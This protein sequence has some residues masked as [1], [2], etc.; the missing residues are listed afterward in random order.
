MSAAPKLKEHLTYK[1]YLETSGNDYW[2][3]IDGKAYSMSPA[4]STTHQ[5]I[6]RVVTTKIDTYLKGK[7]CE[8]F[9]APFDVRLP[10]ADQNDEST[11]NV[12]Q[13]DLLVICDQEKIDEKG[14]K[15]APDFIIEI[16]SNSTADRDHFEKLKLYEQAGVKEYWIV[17][18]WSKAILVHHL[19]EGQYDQ[20]HGYRFKDDVIVGTLPGLIINLSELLEE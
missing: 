1:D 5:R 3:I 2:E 16:L 14:C 19:K 11:D 20:A 15:G 10:K 9:N 4:P 8:V 6:S 12:V 13:P 17:N 7:P 18:P